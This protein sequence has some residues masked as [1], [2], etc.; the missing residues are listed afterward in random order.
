MNTNNSSQVQST[1]SLALEFKSDRNCLPDRDLI[2]TVVALANTNGGEV[3]LGVENDGTVSGLHPNHSEFEGISALVANKTKPQI[4]V[5]V[6]LCETEDKKFVKIHV[7]KSRHL[8][9]TSDGRYLRRQLKGD[10]TP[11]DVPI[12][13][14][15]IIQRQSTIGLLDPSGSVLENISS[16]QLDPLQRQ[17]IRNAIEKYAGEKILLSLSDE[18]FDGALGLCQKRNGISHPTVAGLLLLGTESLLRQHIPAHEVA[19]QVLQGTN[20]RV[21]EFFRK[22]LMETF[23]AVEMLFQSRVEEDEVQVGL[24][25]VGV[26]NYD[27]RAF[28]E[29]FVNA[30]VHRD[31]SR[32][33]QVIVR[34]DDDGL[35]ISNPGGFIEGVTLDNLLVADP[36][37]RN[38]LLADIVKRI[39]LAERT[40]RGVDRIYEGMLRY[41]RPSPD[42][43]RTSDVTVALQLCN[44]APDFGFLKMVL[45]YEDKYGAFPIDTMIILSRLRDERR[46]AVSD[47]MRFIQKS[48]QQTHAVLE[49]LVETGFLEPHGTGR[50]RVYTL[51]ASVYR[52]TGQKIEYIRQVGITSIRQENMILT[53]I[54]KHSQI[55]RGEVVKL[56]GLNPPQA[57][58]LLKKLTNGGKIVK[59]GVKRHAFYTQHRA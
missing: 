20:V 41:G 8:V 22:P 18:E 33:G 24:F 57:Y 26:P 34:L 56:C 7:Q 40:G 19:F 11:E 44:A 6:E 52:H 35:Y 54:E 2:N 37:S 38:P 53:F 13:P 49:K 55:T 48:E 30:L 46:L 21:N 59:N 15:E 28:R 27:K 10:G 47:F 29:A 45:D 31:F 23:E 12:F 25:R 32:L 16:A 58:R 17:R 50:G 5:R 43:S 4:Y 9:S 51:S 3:W 39:G 42:Y 36:R 14:N 1:E